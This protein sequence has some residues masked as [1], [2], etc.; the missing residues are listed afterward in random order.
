MR[1]TIQANS[2]DPLSQCRQDIDRIDGVLVAL[3]RERTRLAMQ[4]GEIKLTHGE[5]I[6]AAAREAAVLRR[7]Q[8]LAVPPLAPDA[9]VRI[10]ACI[11]DETR[12]AEQTARPTTE[13]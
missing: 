12:A 5:P 1:P 8:Q 6:H 7:V 10:F 3:L 11:I 13:D 4:A 9:I 2:P